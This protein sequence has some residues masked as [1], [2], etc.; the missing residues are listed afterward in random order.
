MVGGFVS[1]GVFFELRN[2]PTVEA[3]CQSA[4]S[5]AAVA[6]IIL[7]T[8]E[9]GPDDLL[10]RLRGERDAADAAAAAA[11]VSAAAQCGLN[12]CTWFDSYV[13]STHATAQRAA[14]RR[15]RAA[16]RRETPVAAP[17]R[18]GAMASVQ[19]WSRMTV[20][21][22]T[23]CHAARAHGGRC[24]TRTSG[25]TLRAAANSAGT[26]PQTPFEML[27]LLPLR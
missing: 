15:Q 2:K 6:Q 17:R 26:P 16:V 8:F 23:L 9:G 11:R 27:P 4:D 14:R 24:T 13:V 18:E 21:E 22:M 20:M 1:P 5:D 12:L 7:D 19:S 10:Q 3:A 25:F